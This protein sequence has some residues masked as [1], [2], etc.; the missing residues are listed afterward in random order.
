[1]C[2]MPA[3]SPS[4]S[5]EAKSG[6][7]PPYLHKRGKVYYFKRKIPSAIA[8]AFRP[9]TEQVWKSLET[10]DF[11]A[12]LAA[13]PGPVAAF[14][15]IAALARQGKNPAHLRASQIRRRGEGTTKYLLEAHIPSLLAVY[16]Y[17]HLSTDDEER[18]GTTKAERIVRLAEF[19]VQLEQL[20]DQVAAE[21]RTAVQEVARCLLSGE[22][23]IAPPNCNALKE[24][25]IQLLAADIDILGIQCDR[26]RGKV[27]RTPG[28]P[29]PRPREMKTLLDVHARWEEGQTIQRT[30]D[31]YRGFVAE[32]EAVARALPVASIEL[33]HAEALRDHLH[34]QGLAKETIV[35]YLG[36][37][38]TLIRSGQSKGVVPKGPNPFE[39]VDMDMLPA[40]LASE[41]RRGFEISELRLFFN[42]ELYASAYRPTGQTA[43]AAYWAPL[44]ALFTGARI[45]EISQARMEDVQKINGAWAIR[46]A[47]LDPEQK[48]KTLSSFRHVPLHEELIKCGFLSF[49]ARQKLAGCK[50]LFPALTN[51]NKNGTF[52]NALTKF[53]SRYL[54]RTGLDDDRLVFHSFRFSFKQQCVLCGIED[55]THDALTGHWVSKSQAGRGYLKEERRQYPFPPLGK[56]IKRLQF[57]ELD[58]SHLH[59]AK[60]MEFVDAA[61][62]RFDEEDLPVPVKR[63]R[64]RISRLAT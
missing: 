63:T 58:L 39:G 47:N 53:L 7:R 48:L 42:T 51:N 45:E 38:A 12:A 5:T 61:F 31:S 41:E 64:G 21:D 2:A 18:E 30:I 17:A 36:G 15:T 11:E 23:L 37:L 40:R 22:R 32:F 1:M 62:S 20:L 26:L 44:V 33:K 50:R 13:L 56:A 35:N 60:P 14:E 3:G 6:P 59:V 57:G 25:E 8:E 49:I 24:L 27:H 55:S 34:D 52:S 29:P 10:E 16:A 9:A 46:F 19:E 28:A 4:S 54:D 43:E